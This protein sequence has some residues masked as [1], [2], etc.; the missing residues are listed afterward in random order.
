MTYHEFLGKVLATKDPLPT[1]KKQPYRL[2]EDLELLYQLSNFK[3]VEVKTFETIS[4][5]GRISRTAESLRSRYNEHLIK[6]SEVEMKK[7]VAWVEKEGLEGYMTFDES[8][9]IALSLQEGGKDSSKEE[10]KRPRPTSLDTAEKKIDRSK[11]EVLKKGVPTNCKELNEVMRVYSKM[12]NMPIK[13]LLELLDQLSGDFVQLDNYIES[14]DVRLLWSG[15]EDEALRKGVATEVEM[16]RKYR[17]SAVDS[18]RK[19]LG[20]I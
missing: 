3:S 9:G 20:L 6:I 11:K 19:Y 1:G 4:S 13:T 15:E 12:V 16:L 8:A 2:Q 17:G 18:R 7:I 10:K 5:S 14:K